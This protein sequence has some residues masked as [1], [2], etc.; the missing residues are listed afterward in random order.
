M[1]TIILIFYANNFN[2]YDFNLDAHDTNH[3]SINVLKIIVHCSKC[4]F[5]VYR[6]DKNIH[7]CMYPQIKSTMDNW[8]LRVFITRK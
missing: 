3:I 5:N 1:M 7:G 2:I 8:Y 6:D 4:K